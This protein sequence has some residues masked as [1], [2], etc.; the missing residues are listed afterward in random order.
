MRVIHVPIALPRHNRTIVA[1]SCTLVS[2]ILLF[3]AAGGVEWHHMK[4]SLPPAGLFSIVHSEHNLRHDTLTIC[5][6]DQHI[7]GFFATEFCQEVHVTYSECEDK[8][9]DDFMSQRFW[10]NWACLSYADFAKA[11]KCLIAAG[12]GTVLSMGLG[13]YREQLHGIFVLLSSA[14]TTA[15]IILFAKGQSFIN[16]NGGKH[17][18]TVLLDP[19]ANGTYAAGSGAGIYLCAVSLVLSVFSALLTLSLFCCSSRRDNQ[20]ENEPS[21]L[22]TSSNEIPAADVESAQ[23]TVEATPNGNVDI[24]RQKSVTL[25]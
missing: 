16:Q 3:I 10:M 21:S 8:P 12:C 2:A 15:G 22:N 25:C 17:V 11:S 20:I 13:F 9:T 6:K 5:A 4:L 19:H 7:D 23:F 18:I 14:V 24:S 1:F